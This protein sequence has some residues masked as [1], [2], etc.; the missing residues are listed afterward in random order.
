M[1]PSEKRRRTDDDD[2]EE[3]LERLTK[4]SKKPEAS[5]QKET[6]TIRSENRDGCDSR[7]SITG[8]TIL[9]IISSRE[10]GSTMEWLL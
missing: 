5:N 10:Y 6:F 7:W 8:T 4:S 1:R 3:L 9:R 2:E